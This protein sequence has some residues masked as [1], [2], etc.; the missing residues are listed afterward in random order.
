[1]QNHSSFAGTDDSGG[2]R[3][4]VWKPRSHPSQSRILE[5]WFPR[6][7]ISQTCHSQHRPLVGRLTSPFSY[8]VGP[9]GDDV[10]EPD[11]E[12]STSL[13]SV[14]S[15][16]S[17]SLLRLLLALAC[18]IPAGIVMRILAAGPRAPDADADDGPASGPVAIE[19][20]TEGADE[21]EPI[22]PRGDVRGEGRMPFIRPCCAVVGVPGDIL[23]EAGG[24]ECCFPFALA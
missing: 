23:P 19:L 3:Q 9:S 20:R 12:D 13:N 6:P 1:M 10:L 5:A 17:V 16:S 15:L 24:A 11:L 7:Q 14:S 2:S 18:P 4:Y 22:R 8:F 21:S